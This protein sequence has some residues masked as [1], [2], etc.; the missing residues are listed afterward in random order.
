MDACDEGTVRLLNQYTFS[1]YDNTLAGYI[2]VTGGN[3]EVCVNGTFLQ[4]CNSP[5]VDQA[6][7]NSVC[8]YLGYDGQSRFLLHM[9]GRCSQI[10]MNQNDT[11]CMTCSCNEKCIVLLGI[12][13]E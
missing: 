8:Y 7:A 12:A 1:S 9:N 10:C 3:L 11:E 6:L 4:V 13:L 5:S 2:E